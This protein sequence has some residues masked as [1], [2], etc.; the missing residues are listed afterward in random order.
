VVDE[1]AA[2][3]EAGNVAGGRTWRAQWRR[4]A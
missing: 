3:G 1:T 4:D 2:G